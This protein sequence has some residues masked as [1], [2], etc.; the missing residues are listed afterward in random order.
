MLD[1]GVGGIT[2]ALM[3][4]EEMHTVPITTLAWIFYHKRSESC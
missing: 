3:Q 1:V 4:N 2:Q